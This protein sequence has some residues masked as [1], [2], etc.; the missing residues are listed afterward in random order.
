M[1]M[2]LTNAQTAVTNVRVTKLDPMTFPTEMSDAPLAMANAETVSSGRLEST[3]TPRMVITSSLTPNILASGPVLWMIS[4]L[5][6]HSRSRPPMKATAERN[7]PTSS[8][9][10][11]G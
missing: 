6:P 8:V 11:S 4:S 9:L 3:L 10:D 7:I 1:S 5:L 2:G